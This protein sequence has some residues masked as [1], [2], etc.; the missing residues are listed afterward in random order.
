MRISVLGPLRVDDAPTDLGRR[1]R[2]VLSA[3][4]LRPGHPVASDRLADAL[5]G[6]SPPASAAKVVQGCVARLRKLLGAGVIET[7]AL[8]YRLVVDESDV[9]LARFER[10]VTRGRQLLGLGEPE[11]AAYVFGEALSCFIGDPLP[12]LD[13]WGTGVI[14]AERL[15]ELRLG[16]EEGRVEALLR[17]GH[18]DEVLA[19]AQALV[20]ARPLREHR[21]ALLALAQYRAGRQSDALASLRAVRRTLVAELAVEPSPALVQLERAILDQDPDLLVDAPRA[22]RE[23]CP[24]PG[25]GVY[26]VP[27]A[28]SFHGRDGDVVACLTL[29][30]E[31]GVL[32]VV[33]PSGS[34]KSSLL[35]AGVV[36]T[37]RAKGTQVL[38]MSPGVAPE[39]ELGAIDRLPGGSLLVVDQCEEIFTAE[40]RPA[41]R[42]R[43][44]AAVADHAERGKVAVALRADRLSDLSASPSFARLLERGLYILGVMD[45]DGLRACIERP[46]WQAG[47]FVEPGLVDV[48]TAEVRDEPGALPLLSHALQETWRRREGRTL[49]VEGYRASGGI[50]GS[51]AQS[52]EGVYARVPTTQRGQVRDLMMRLVAPGPEG[53]PLRVRV[54]RRR[55][56]PGAD[57]DRLLELLVTAR[58]LT[59]DSG[60]V[61]LAHESLARA[62]PR[63]RGWLDDDREG[64][65]ILHHLSASADS[66]HDLDRPDSELYRGVRLARVA[67]WR[68]TS[69]ARLAPV[70]QEFIDASSA[71][72]A[73][74]EQSDH[75][76]ARRQVLV[77]RRLQALLAGAIVLALVAGGAGVLARRN[78]GRAAAAATTAEARQV[79]ASAQVTDDAPKALLLAAAAAQLDPSALPDL[80]Q[81]LAERPQL[82]RTTY[83]EG[84]ES[85]LMTVSPDGTRLAVHDTAGGIVLY[86]ADTLSLLARAQAGPHVEGWQ[87]TPVEFSPDGVELAAAA[88]P[89]AGRPVRLLDP[90]TLEPRDGQLG[91]WPRQEGR[92]DGVAYS[93]DGSRIAVTL[94]LDASGVE[95]SLL[96]VWDRSRPERP[97]RRIRLDASQGVQISPDGRTVWVA[98]PFASYDV[99][100]GRELARNDRVFS[101]LFFEPSPDHETFVAHGYAQ[102]PPSVL[103]LVDAGTGRITRRLYGLPGLNSS[104]VAWSPD[105][106]HVAGTAGDGAAVVWDPETG[107]IE[108][109]LLTEDAT[110]YG[111]AFSPDGST[112]YTGGSNRQVQAWDLDGYRSFLSRVPLTREVAIDAAFVRPSPDG[113]TFA[114]QSG[115]PGDRHEV[116]FI[117][118][119]EDRTQPAI[120]LDDDRA[121]GAGGWSPDGERFAVG[122]GDGWVRVLGVAENRQLVARRAG[123]SLVSEVAYAAD[124]EVIVMTEESGDLTVLDAATLEQRRDRIHFDEPLLHVSTNPRD[125]T[126]FVLLGGPG[127]RWFERY[128]ARAWATVDLGSGTV[129]RRGDL[130][131]DGGEYT[132]FSPDGVHAVVA[133]RQ[134]QLEVVDTVTG[135]TVVGPTS[136][137]RGTSTWVTY[138]ADGSQILT[139]GTDR[140]ARR[141]DA[142]T[143][144][145]LGAARIPGAGPPYGGWRADGS[146]LL[147]SMAG[148]VYSWD[149]TLEHA[150]A[151]ACQAAGRDLTRAE[152][153]QAFPGRSFRSVCPGT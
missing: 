8:G 125:D 112:L 86:D 67:E 146:L 63:L 36:A 80:Q 124:G 129:L 40:H 21:H 90:E 145:L 1:D 87:G 3:L 138:S 35:R 71:L 20:R 30:A 83:L 15:T 95:R 105:G 61:T 114:L 147:T 77:N 110:T 41:T 52:A 54:P 26:D 142:R 11:R 64:Q 88:V 42:A 122:Y 100:S 33:G 51:I 31:R 28:E 6:A 44:L 93:D 74:E 85:G 118:V 27:D 69:T 92:A 140:S 13:G 96:L 130:G 127:G 78:A 38:V 49:T 103:L 89:S 60:N 104:M 72:R 76:R 24:W 45:D 102:G 65:R 137:L 34:G 23:T 32:A 139:S 151:F 4:A 79:G 106:R 56:A 111:L 108:Q 153:G 94:T 19:D 50:R 91:G 37:A 59:S 18:H 97:V 70:E 136:R 150:I 120:R 101:W 17:A 126:A 119:D 68:E 55:I 117:D 121:W 82:V 7:T 47:L 29:L 48:L 148:Q 46:A 12:D 123:T 22:L 57:H 98:G 10:L 25:L 109:T 43:F 144:V 107:E 58:L 62:W 113:G 135:A 73:R 115:V 66:W 128:A 5:W 75:D 131:L 2:V 149:T 116:R 9:D 81:T 143:G 152:W 53:E 99:D 84:G 141:Y 16:T 133:G 14:E 132:A 39:H 134:S